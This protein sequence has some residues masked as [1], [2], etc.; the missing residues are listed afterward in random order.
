[1]LY[2][3]KN[4]IISLLLLFVLGNAFMYFP[5]DAV[6]NVNSELIDSV[7]L[8]G[9]K[10][11]DFDGGYTV[12]YVY[13]GDTIAV[14]MNGQEVKVRFI[15]VD[16]PES[17]HRN[18]SLNSPEGKESS[19]FTKELLEGKQVYLEY[20]VDKEDDYGRILAYVY[21]EDKVMVNA[22]L[23]EKGYAKCMSIKPNNRY[24]DMFSGIE[25]TAKETGIG[26]WG[27]GFF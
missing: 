9:A 26:F 17:V 21:T 5:N 27:N 11:K 16:T 14:L 2:K 8:E 20:D 23:L 1:M 24:A 4:L 18:E 3:L 25:K 6:E 13:D 15:G 12:T 22:L 7:E 19:N 10:S